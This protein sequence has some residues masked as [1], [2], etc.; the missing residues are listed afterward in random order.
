MSIALLN[1]HGVTSKTGISKSRI[2]QLVRI[3]KFPRPR[4]VEDGRVVWLASMV[5]D[6]I[7][8][9]WETAPAAGTVIG[10]EWRPS[11]KAA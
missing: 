9:R 11:K 10:A 1:V 4:K 3:G 6:W 8:E 2:Y 7:T 5:E